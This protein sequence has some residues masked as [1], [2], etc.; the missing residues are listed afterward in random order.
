MS[1]G[2]IRDLRLLH[3]NKPI[4]R[5]K[6]ELIDAMVTVLANANATA[7]KASD[8]VIW[9]IYR[10]LKERTDIMS[11]FRSMDATKTVWCQTIQDV[12]DRIEKSLLQEFDETA[13]ELKV[14]LK[15][16]RISPDTLFNELETYLDEMDRVKISCS[17]GNI[18]TAKKS[19]LNH[20]R[21]I[22]ALVEETVIKTAKKSITPT[23]ESLLMLIE[24]GQELNDET[25]QMIDKAERIA[26]SFKR[27]N[28]VADR[29]GAKS[30]Y[31]RERQV[32]DKTLVAIEDRL[33]LWLNQHRAKN[34][35]VAQENIL[36]LCRLIEITA[37]NRRSKDAKRR[38]FTGFNK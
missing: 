34:P 12:R 24:T 20:I 8:M 35:E 7:P 18:D 25:A 17:R 2:A 36:Y 37:G 19:A 21:T 10:R 4:V 5:P 13:D 9:T 14:A 6:K 29:I 27:L 33:K 31:E 38:L 3:P 22:S 1:A 11:V 30:S 26:L 16:G 32:L 15:R 28:S 23:V